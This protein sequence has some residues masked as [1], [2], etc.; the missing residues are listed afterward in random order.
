MDL[1]RQQLLHIFSITNAREIIVL[2]EIVKI[3][4]F[5]GWKYF[6]SRDLSLENVY[7]TPICSIFNDKV[8]NVNFLSF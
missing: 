4:I 6:G 1:G 5:Q 8:F 2:N 3:E 7:M